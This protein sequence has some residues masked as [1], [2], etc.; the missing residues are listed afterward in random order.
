M[1]KKIRRIF[2]VKHWSPDDKIHIYPSSRYVE[3]VTIKKLKTLDDFADMFDE[4]RT[5]VEHIHL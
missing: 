5:E 4:M 3:K 1:K 2:H